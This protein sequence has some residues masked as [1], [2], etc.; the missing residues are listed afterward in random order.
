MIQGSKTTILVGY[1]QSTHHENKRNLTQKNSENMK[2]ATI[3]IKKYRKNTNNSNNKKRGAL[4]CFFFDTQ[5][6]KQKNT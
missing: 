4:M 5:A 2:K 1:V 3:T 6:R